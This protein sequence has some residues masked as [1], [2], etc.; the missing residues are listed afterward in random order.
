MMQDP[1]AAKEAQEKLREMANN[2]KTAE[3]KKALED[4]AKQAAQIAKEMGPKDKPAPKPA[5]LKN[6]ADKLAGKDEKAKA[7]AR[8]QLADMMK[9][10]KAREEALKRLGE[11]AKNAKAEDKQALQEALKQAT[12]L[13]KNPPPPPD[14]RTSR[15]WPTSST[16]WTRR[17]GRSSANKS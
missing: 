7:D 4:A 11:M 13:A 5:D 10:P 1:K 3:D 12:E 17:K 14:P 2:A 8:K 6:M 16:R 15:S 9:D